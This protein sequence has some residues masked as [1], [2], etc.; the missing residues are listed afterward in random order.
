[1]ARFDQF[2]AGH[3]HELIVA[4]VKCAE[5]AAVVTRRHR[6]RGW[7][8][9][10][11]IIEE[12]VVRAQRL[13]QVGELSAGRHAQEGADW[14]QATPRTLREF[15]STTQRAAPPDPSVSSISRRRSSVA[16]F[17]LHGRGQQEVHWA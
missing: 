16:T 10:P 3:W 7:S 17:D 15:E 4:S 6:R 9:C 5:D 2:V 13:V 14:H 12:R 11:N 8:G 1:M